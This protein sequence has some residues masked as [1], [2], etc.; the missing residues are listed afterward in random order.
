[1]S[2]PR[3]KTQ[4]AI[5]KGNR[6][7]LGYGAVEDT[8]R[9]RPTVRKTTN[10][11]SILTPPK[12]DTASA[13]V[14]D[15]RRNMS[16]LAWMIRRHLDNVSRFTPHFRLSANTPAAQTEVDAVNTAVADMLAWHG[17]RRQFD[18]LGRHGRNEYLRM[19][20]ACKVISGDCGSLKVKGGKSQGIEGDRIKKPGANAGGNAADAKKYKDVTDEGMTFN[21]DGTRK[22]FCLCKRGKGGKM[23]FE[24]IIPEADMIFDGYWPERLTATGESHRF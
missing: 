24:R 1:M 3:L 4:A 10:E 2:G 15:D 12:R 6:Y 22:G 8:T 18:A 23:E 14:R 17:R 20:E 9:R 11:A 7:T 21:T 19:F 16:I 13:T 5:V